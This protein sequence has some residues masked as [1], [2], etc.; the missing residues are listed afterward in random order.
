MAV[1]FAHERFELVQTLIDTGEGRSWCVTLYVNRRPAVQAIR[2]DLEEA[3]RVVGE[4]WEEQF[5]RWTLAGTPA[6][7]A[8]IG[9]DL[10]QV[11]EE[12]QGRG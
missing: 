7:A 6:N 12:C 9:V 2:C 5:A 1:D 4:L 3:V 8:S 10:Q 11:F